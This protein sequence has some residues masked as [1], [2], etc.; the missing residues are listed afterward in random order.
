MPKFKVGDQVERIINVLPGPPHVGTVRR[1]IPNGDDYD[2]LMEYEVEFKD[3][4]IAIFYETELRLAK[5]VDA[6]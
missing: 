6:G 1:V 2:M 3:R 5:A 4:Q